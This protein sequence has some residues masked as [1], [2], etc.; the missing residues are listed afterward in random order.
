M[1]LHMKTILLGSKASEG[2]FATR[3]NETLVGQGLDFLNCVDKQHETATKHK[4]N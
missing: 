1:H 2:I 3:V 4:Q